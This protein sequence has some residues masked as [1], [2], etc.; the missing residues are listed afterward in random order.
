MTLGR[1]GWSKKTRYCWASHDIVDLTCICSNSC[2]GC[3]LFAS[4]RVFG[5]VGVVYLVAGGARACI[6]LVETALIDTTVLS[7][8]ICHRPAQDSI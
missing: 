5:V 3:H 7:Q 1:H 6:W 4:V 8:A 2:E